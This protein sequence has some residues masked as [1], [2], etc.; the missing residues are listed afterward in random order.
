MAKDWRTIF[1][2]GG[3]GY[4]GSH[5]IV[6]LLESGYD[7][8]AID[9]FA[10]S[11]TESS[12][13]SAALKRVEQITGKKV[14]FYNCD[15]IDRDKLETVFKK[16][17]I[18][19]VIHFAAIKAV[20]ESMQIPLHYYRNNIIGAINLLEV[21]K[22]AGCFQLV[23]SSS[24][25]V[26]GEPNVLPITE[27]HP[28]GNITNVYGRTKYFIE[29]MLKDISRA[30]KNWNIISLRYFNPVGAHQSGLIGEDPTK[31][32]TNLMP[33]IAQVALRH[34]PELIIFGG[35]YPTKDGTGIRD[36]IHVMDLAAG[37]VA[38]LNALHKRHLRLKIYN[39]GTG[40]G[41][42]VLELIKIFENVTG[43]TVPYVIKDRREGDIVSM[44]ANTDLAEKELE[45]RTKFNVERMCEDFWRWQTMNP[46]GYRNSV[47]NGI[48]EH[49][50]GTL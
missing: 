6:E 30:E 19:C 28:T 17:K 23:F 4:I 40:K 29:E 38:A 37:H 35:D 20:G 25:T 8:V 22:A 3:A 5:C 48:S 33:Y 46:H 11:V 41:V 39:L 15:L 31:S 27:E 36:Y 9:N 43:T 26:Y 45:W 1:V 32:F 2:T 13:E 12:G 44:Y 18:D 47:K 16:H 14:T 24:C 21:M 7:V 42:S 49:V 10:N 34:K 50:N